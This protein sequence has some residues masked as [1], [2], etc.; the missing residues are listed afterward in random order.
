MSQ[1]A[2]MDRE[3]VRGVA[4]AVAELLRR[5]NE[6]FAREIWLAGTGLAKVPRWIDDFDAKP[7]R[8]AIRKWGWSR[9]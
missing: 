3:F 4:Y 6:V 7:I 8:A 5:D 2:Q 9:G 1:I